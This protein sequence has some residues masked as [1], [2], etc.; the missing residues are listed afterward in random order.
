M[1]IMGGSRL[2]NGKWE[3]EEEILITPMTGGCE[4][5]GEVLDQ[6]LGL[7]KVRSCLLAEEREREVLGKGKTSLQ[8]GLTVDRRG[9]VEFVCL[10]LQ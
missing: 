5:E 6:E 7:S 1:Y 2:R 9:R 10:Q 4:G 3:R 8:V